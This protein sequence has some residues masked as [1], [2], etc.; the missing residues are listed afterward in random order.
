MLLKI[1]KK[2]FYLNATISIC[3][4]V[5]DFQKLVPRFL[6]LEEIK[7]ARLNKIDG[8]TSSCIA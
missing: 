6:I 3:A 4:G 2:K 7:F 8:D 5:M 1:L